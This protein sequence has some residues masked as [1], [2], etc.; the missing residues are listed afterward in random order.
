MMNA[1]ENINQRIAGVR[2]DREHGSR[3]LV[4]NAIVIIR[5]L[6]ALDL[7]PRDE[8]MRQLYT[9]GRALA[10]ARPAMAALASAM[11]QLF[12]AAETPTLIYQRA[13]HLLEEYDTAVEHIAG[14]ARPYLHG[15]LMTC[16]LSGTII[17]VLVACKQQ[18]TQVIVL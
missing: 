12:V 16:S 1:S 2:E 5:D 8:H 14:H 17:E 10:S 13:T 7:E 9:A 3:W 15:Q 11:G 4:R 6:A 18:I